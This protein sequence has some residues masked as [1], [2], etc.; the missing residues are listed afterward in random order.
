DREGAIATW[1]AALAR[2]GDDFRVRM[3]L[4]RMALDAEDWPKAEEHFLAA[5]RCFPGFDDPQVSAEL[6][7]VAVY[8]RTD[9]VD[10][11]NREREAWLAYNAG[12]LRERRKVASWHLEHE[13]FKEAAVELEHANEVDPFVRS[14][15]REWGI[16][17][18]ALGRN[19][20]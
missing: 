1:E 19:E 4:G 12:D 5:K 18:E 20:E 3:A 13:R 14:M 11:A 17:L 15:H 7:L 8:T 2:G 16:A 10:D 6:G 9:R